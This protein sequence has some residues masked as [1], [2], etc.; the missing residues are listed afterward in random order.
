[1]GV[2]LQNTQAPDYPIRIKEFRKRFGLTQTRMAELLGVSFAS[3]NR[4][5]NGQ[6]KPNRLVWKQF[7]RAEYLG[8]EALSR[9]FSPAVYAHYTVNEPKGIYTTQGDVVPPLDFST[10]AEIV[11][12]VVEGER[13]AYGHL[14][15][16]AFASETS[17]IDP[18][19]HQRMAV[20]EHML[21][22]PRLRFLLADDAGAGKTI[23][24]G[25]YIREMLAR[26]LIH[27]VLIVPP[28]GL[29][30]N[31][32]R[33]LRML[34][35]LPVRV[36]V[37][38]EAKSGNPFLEPD[39]DL[40]IVSI[41]TLAGDKMFAR[42]QESGVR[43]YDLVIFDEAHKLSADRQPDFTIRKT[44]RYKLA[45][46]L[47]G[48]RTDDQRWQL[49]WSA[50]HLVLLTATPHMGKDYPYYCLWRLLEPETLSTFD[51]FS[52][53]PPDA[54]KRHFI[55]RTKEEMVRFDGSQ[56]YPKRI[57]DTLS[58]DLTHGTISEQLLYDETTA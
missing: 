11:R 39:T 56:I 45:E 16:P 42:L 48:V 1:M 22:Q 58:Y 51:A 8:V 44:D 21:T 46:A 14:Y 41:D 19:P 12:V 49:T 33:E 28:A 57:S 43:P 23:M 47:A 5:E 50:R 32:E 52:S 9:D 54:R 10:P 55:R 37:G 36:A 25:L 6:T 2:P 13:L 26:R 17:H 15:N 34:F 24:A 38:S 4:W 53:Y 30:S 7:V 40:L 35:S 31:W 18:L 20:Y 3:V 27:R 29:V